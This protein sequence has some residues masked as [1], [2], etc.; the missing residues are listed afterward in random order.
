M[1]HPLIF[2]RVFNQPWDISEAAY[3][4]IR[5]SFIAYSR[6]GSP[7]PSEFLDGGFVPG[8]FSEATQIGSLGIVP[9]HGIIGKMLS[10]METQCGGC[11]V[12]QVRS[13]L[14]EA[15]ANVSITDI[16]LHIDT[17][18]GTSQGSH[19]LA[20]FVFELSRRRKKGLVAYSETEATSAGYHIG[21]QAQAFFAAPSAM[22][23]SIGSII[24]LVN[25]E[26]RDDLEGLQYTT[27]TSGKFKD[28][29][30]PHRQATE[31][32]LQTLQGMVEKSATNFKV[33]VERSRGAIPEGA[34]QAELFDAQRALDLGMVDALF[35]TAEDLIATLV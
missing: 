29:G 20:D 10:G 27:I 15:F 35:D 18:G 11:D 25:S 32:E 34:R 3:D 30:N 14:S 7:V 1:K 5:Q 22:V 21:S 6:H 16:L 12:D 31:E 26:K 19:E 13:D 2:D 8:K 17:P 24:T 28:I 33:N 9:I 4:S 23:G